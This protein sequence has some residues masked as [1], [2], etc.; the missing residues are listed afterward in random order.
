LLD[1]YGRA[2]AEGPGLFSGPKFNTSMLRTLNEK[3]CKEEVGRYSQET[4]LSSQMVLAHAKRI[5]DQT[6]I[7]AAEEVLESALL[8]QDRLAETE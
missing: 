4:V 1:S 5:G 2:A 8:A 7:N 3:V 6:R